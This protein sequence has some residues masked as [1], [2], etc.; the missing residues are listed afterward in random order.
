MSSICHTFFYVKNQWPPN[1][2]YFSGNVFV[3]IKWVNAPVGKFEMA[4]FGM[5]KLANL[6][7]FTLEC[8]FLMESIELGLIIFC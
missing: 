8:R 6:K 5:A 1:D 3:R 7:C 4:K 2:A